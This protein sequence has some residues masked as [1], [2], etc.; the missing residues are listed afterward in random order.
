[1][2]HKLLYAVFKK[3]GKPKSHRFRHTLATEILAKGGTLDNVAGVLGISSAVAGK[4]HVKWSQDRQQRIDW[5]MRIVHGNVY[6]R[7]EEEERT[8]VQ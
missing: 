6:E 5:V 8:T 4:H 7:G 2:G 1:M 3:A